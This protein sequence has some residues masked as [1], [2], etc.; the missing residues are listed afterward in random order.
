[1]R[2]LL[3]ASLFL[4]TGFLLLLVPWSGFWERNYFAQAL[5]A[6]EAFI[7]NNYVRG[8]VSGLGLV[9]LYLG[10]A[11]L[12][13]SITSRPSPPTSLGASSISARDQG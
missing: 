7:V 13:A 2:R 6:V 1:V 12:V 10:L 4:W 9:N 11:E 3:L 8:A 5:P